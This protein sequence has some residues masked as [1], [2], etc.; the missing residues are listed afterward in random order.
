MIYYHVN[1]REGK[2]IENQRALGGGI[3]SCHSHWGE[4]LLAFSGQRPRKQGILQ[5]NDSLIQNKIVPH[6]GKLSHTLHDT[7]KGIYIG[8]KPMYND[9]ESRT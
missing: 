2:V 6:H 4:A 8:E 7:L 3:F 5:G 9:V 1:F